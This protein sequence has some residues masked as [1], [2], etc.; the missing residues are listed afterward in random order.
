LQQTWG[1]EAPFLSADERQHLIAA[2][3]S[4]TRAI[5]RLDFMN[6]SG[7]RPKDVRVA[8]LG[9][10]LETKVETLWPAP[11]GNSTMPGVSFFGL[12]PAGPG[13]RPG[14]KARLIADSPDEHPGVV[15]PN[16]AI[17]VT[18]SK[19]W[20]YVETGPETYER[21]AV[22][23]DAPVDDGF[24]VRT[25]FEPGERVV[26]QGASTLLAREAEPGSLDD[27]DDDGGAPAAATPPPAST[28]GKPAAS[29]AIAADRAAR[30][31]D[32]D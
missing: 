28:T 3:S 4:G 27:D 25:G 23:L 17:V 24:L 10:G 16:A 9:G 12:V 20:C 7:G 31:S 21:K 8:P 32:A 5:V 19:S 2:I 13:L 1:D 29:A 18:Q 11:S 22:S 14:D 26:V 30:H 6:L 15:I